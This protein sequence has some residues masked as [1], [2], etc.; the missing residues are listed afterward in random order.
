MVTRD[1]GDL[2]L[3]IVA[4]GIFAYNRI[5]LSNFHLRMHFCFLFLGTADAVLTIAFGFR[6]VSFLNLSK[7]IF[8]Y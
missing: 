2:Y 6:T 7:D 1:C 8:V 5:N 4:F 3:N